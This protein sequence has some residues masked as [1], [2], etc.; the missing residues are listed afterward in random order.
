[1]RVLKR[2]IQKVLGAFG[3]KIV[4]LDRSSSIE[5]KNFRNLV[6]VYEHQLNQVAGHA[7]IPPDPMRPELLIRLL[8]TA[9][10]EAYFIIQALAKTRCLEG[11]VCEFGV[12]QGETSALIAN[13]IRG[14]NKILHLFDSFQGLPAP[15]AQDKLKDDIFLLGSI[16]AYAGT[17]ASPEDMV[18]SRLNDIGI[19]RDHYVLHKGFIEQVLSQDNELPSR[20]SF[21]YVDFDFYEPI[22]STL[23]FLHL[24][25]PLGAIIIVDD[26]DWFSTGAKAAVDEFIAETNG[27][28]ECYTIDVYK[29]PY[30]YFAVLCKTS[31]G[32]Q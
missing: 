9:P 26:Y 27:S 31:Q 16:E 11:D 4:A 3:Y 10:S 24:V 18:I 32:C 30:G 17:M 1:M 15:S 2:G 7:L 13:E 21:A 14:T 22:K 29:E 8:G 23:N 20:V 19:P 25:T 28:D 5:F 6:Q 12:A